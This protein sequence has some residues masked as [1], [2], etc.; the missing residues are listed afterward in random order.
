[1]RIRT[2]NT[3]DAYELPEKLLPFVT[4]KVNPINGKTYA[5]V[6]NEDY[7]KALARRCAPTSEGKRARG[8][9]Y[10]WEVVG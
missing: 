1:M 4:T 3:F 5:S 8:T 6:T 10:T 7:A 9:D 2:D